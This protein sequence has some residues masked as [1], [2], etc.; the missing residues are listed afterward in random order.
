VNAQVVISLVPDAANRWN[1]TATTMTEPDA[2][3]L[4]KEIGAEARAISEAEIHE[5]L[6][7]GPGAYRYPQVLA[8][9]LAPAFDV[10]IVVVSA[11]AGAVTT[12]A[13]DHAIAWAKR[14]TEDHRSCSV[15]VYG[16]DGSELKTIDVTRT[17]VSESPA[18]SA[19]RPANT[20]SPHRHRLRELWRRRPWRR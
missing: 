13:I 15:V 19:R 11:G 14:R 17:R 1:Y 8:S 18:P 7:Y 16:P 10:L 2:T 12:R 4:A 20:D 5:R 6:G 3:V 9:P